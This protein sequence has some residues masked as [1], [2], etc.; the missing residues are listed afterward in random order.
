[1]FGVSYLGRSLVAMEDDVFWHGR[2][3]SVLLY[4][5]VKHYRIYWCTTGGWCDANGKRK[6]FEVRQTIQ[7]APFPKG[8]GRSVECPF[9]MLR[10]VYHQRI[11]M[12]VSAEKG[13]PRSGSFDYLLQC[14]ASHHCGQYELSIFILWDMIP[15][16]GNPGQYSYEYDRLSLV[17]FCLWVTVNFLID[18]WRLD[19]T[20]PK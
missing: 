1:M 7:C 11:V 12:L 17:S 5:L 2:M 8:F 3:C 16:D 19:R 20:P 6:E 9:D 4:W 18:T 13:D 10:I 15:R 14:F